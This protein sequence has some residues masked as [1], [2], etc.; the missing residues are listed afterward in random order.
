MKLAGE[1]LIFIILGFILINGIN[2][3]LSPPS[4]LKDHFISKGI[5]ETGAINLV[6]S[7]YL[8]YRA[9]DTLG[10]TIV[11]LLAVSGIIMLFEARK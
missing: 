7:I 2:I 3:N 8:S 10:E 11:L 1:V 6:S 5:E 4:Q 9:F